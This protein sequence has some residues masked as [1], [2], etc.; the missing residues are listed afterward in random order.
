M[1]SPF[2]MRYLIDNQLLVVCPLLPE[3]RFARYCKERGIRTSERQ[4]ERFEEL[5]IFRPVARVR[6]P[7]N[8]DEHPKTRLKFEE[9]DGKRVYHGTLEEGEDWEGGVEDLLISFSFDK[10]DAYTFMEAG[11]LWE[12]SSRAFKPWKSLKDRSR[13]LRSYYSIFQVYAL[14]NL[15]TATTMLVRPRT[16][17]TTTKK[18]S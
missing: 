13:E 17:S 15:V 10:D 12:P 11:L 6:Y 3:K 5:G 16:T 18:R 1:A 2:D 14:S 8:E 7:E 4:L 9:V